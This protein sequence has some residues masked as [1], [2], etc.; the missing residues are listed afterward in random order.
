MG[1]GWSAQTGEG[2]RREAIGKVPAGEA[3]GREALVAADPSGAPV[4]FN[5]F[6]NPV[7]PEELT[8]MAGRDVEL[9]PV[10]IPAWLRAPPRTGAGARAGGA[11]NASC[12]YGGGRGCPEPVGP[13][14]DFGATTLLRAEAG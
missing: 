14:T 7:G 13:D 10:P 4:L 5:H 3:A 9:R 6:Q 11:G 8:A 2:A 1:A 12:I